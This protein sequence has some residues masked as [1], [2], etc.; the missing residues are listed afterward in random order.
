MITASLLVLAVFSYL[1]KS[2]VMLTSVFGL[3]LALWL[4]RN[5]P[6]SVQVIFLVLGSLVAAI[7]AEV[8]HI[9]Y[10]AYDAARGLGDPPHGGF[11]RSAVLVG[12]INCVAMAPA[13]GLTE[14]WKHR[15]NPT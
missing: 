3:A 1:G 11:F 2:L 14:W 6:L 13:V 4:S 8:V 12:L 15:R 10:H 5:R 9:L 7:A